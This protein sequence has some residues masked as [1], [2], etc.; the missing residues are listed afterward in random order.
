MKEMQNTGLKSEGVEIHYTDEELAKMKKDWP[1]SS[2]HGVYLEPVG[3]HET[4]PF[5][6]PI[7]TK[8]A[9]SPKKPTKPPHVPTPEPPPVEGDD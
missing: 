7:G 1:K 2:E 3:S 5:D 4:N 6:P 9:F 8:G